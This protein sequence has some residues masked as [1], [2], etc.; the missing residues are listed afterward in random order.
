MKKRIKQIGLEDDLNRAIRDTDEGKWT[1]LIEG[2]R[3][4]YI[5][6]V[7]KVY[8][9]DMDKFEQDRE[10]LRDA[11]IQEKGGE[12]YTEWLEKKKEELRVKDNRDKFYAAFRGEEEKAEP[13]EATETK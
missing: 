7:K 1:S 12:Y 2:K 3:G 13:E 8:P 4:A 6:L 10:V 5:A 11:L 9:A